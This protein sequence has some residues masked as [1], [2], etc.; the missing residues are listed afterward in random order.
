M[1]KHNNIYFSL[2]L[3]LFGKTKSV[4]SKELIKH[5]KNIVCARSCEPGSQCRPN[6]CIFGSGKPRGVG[7]LEWGYMSQGREMGS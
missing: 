1:A 4:K 7:I 3:Y 2:S 6:E 5:L